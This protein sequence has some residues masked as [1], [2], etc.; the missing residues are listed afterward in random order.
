MAVVGIISPDYKSP[1]PVN[2]LKTAV[3]AGNIPKLSC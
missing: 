1:Q 3:D 2:N